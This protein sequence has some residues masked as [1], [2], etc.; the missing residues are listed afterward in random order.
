M[1]SWLNKASKNTVENRTYHPVNRELLEITS[2]VPLFK[3][4]Y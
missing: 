3:K 4:T 1:H 2:K